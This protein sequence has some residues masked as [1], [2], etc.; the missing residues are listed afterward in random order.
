MEIF[1]LPYTTK[2]NRVIPKNAFDNYTNTKQKKLFTD[3]IA[4]I[5]WTHKIS[6]DTVNLD[7]KDIKEIQVFTVELKVKEDIKQVLDIIDKA[8]PYIIIFIVVYDSQIYFSTSAKHQHPLNEHNAIVD[9]TFKTG[10]FQLPDNQYKLQL[11][12]SLDAVYLDFCAQ[13]SISGKLSPHSLQKLIDFEKNIFSL[14]KEIAKVKSA[15]TNSRQFNEKVELNLKLK[16]LE[17]E[18]NTIHPPSSDSL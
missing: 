11:K 9:W 13:L 1:S 15:M 16:R 4:R 10:W 14:Q 2:V 5:T 7:F 12:K 3:C 6:T 17:K 8:I 18:L